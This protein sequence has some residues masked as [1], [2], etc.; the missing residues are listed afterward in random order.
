MITDTSNEIIQ[1]IDNGI[2]PYI[3][4]D[5]IKYS[6]HTIKMFSLLFNHIAN[7]REHW[8]LNKNKLKYS[9]YTGIPCD[10]SYYPTKIKKYIHHNI[11]TYY[12]IIFNVRET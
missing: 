1:S 4:M 2:K 10:I 3:K 9:K 11:H 8:N 5:N 7:S 12:K 6:D